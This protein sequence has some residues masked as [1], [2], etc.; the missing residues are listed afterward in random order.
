MST[1]KM[2]AMLTNMN[3][4]AFATSLYKL[5]CISDCLCYLR[6]S[7]CPLSL[8]G[9]YLLALA[10][11]TSVNLGGLLSPSL[12]PPPAFLQRTILTKLYD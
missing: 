5:C 8:L 6:L 11:A 12:D 7:G 4:T 3:P 2:K 9:G 10:M 1:F